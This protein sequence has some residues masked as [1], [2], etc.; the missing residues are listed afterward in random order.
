[1]SKPNNQIGRPKRTDDPKP[2]NCQIAGRNDEKLNRL[3]EKTG[4]GKGRLVDKAIDG[5]KEA[6]YGKA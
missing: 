5:L 1:M 4:I 2:L 6:C 3:K